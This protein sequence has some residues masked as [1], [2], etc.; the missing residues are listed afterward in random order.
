M[1][2]IISYYTSIGLSTSAE[3]KTVKTPSILAMDS[4]V[5][6][7]NSSRSGWFS[8]EHFNGN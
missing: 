4:R 8:V 5:G 3:Q 2:E 6:G 7:V 1:N